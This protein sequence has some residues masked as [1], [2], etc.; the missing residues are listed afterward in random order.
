MDHA[1][2]RKM[3][4]SLPRFAISSSSLEGGLALVGGAELHHM[5]DVMRL[6]A[7]SEIALF[8]EGGVEYSGRI[9]G[10]EQRS[11]VVEIVSTQ[12][13]ADSAARLILAA[14][15]I[16][17]PRMDFLVEK[18]VELGAGELWPIV[19][20]RSVVRAI[21]AQRLDRWRRLTIA[22]AKQSIASRATEVR[23]PSPIADLISR[24]GDGRLRVVMRSDAPPLLRVLQSAR[25]CK[26]LLAVGPEGDFTDEEFQKLR[27]AGFLAAGLGAR[28]L[29]SETAALAALAI[30]AGVLVTPDQEK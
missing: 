30:A 18:A 12:A 23:A 14:A 24:H 4:P 27:A 2:A 16:K 25:P 6:R 20:E 5:R 26:L 21:G 7:G 11:A 13:R 19:C 9:R 3:K 17:G 22:A 10:F 8:D 1:G 28:R 15:M 29:R